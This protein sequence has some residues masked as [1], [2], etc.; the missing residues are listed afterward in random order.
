M[1]E[2]KKIRNICSG[3]FACYNICPVNAISMPL[4]DEGFFYPIINK[5]KCIKCGLCEQV[6]P[7]LNKIKNTNLKPE[8]VFAAKTKDI[9]TQISSSSGG[10]FS[11]LTKPF[12]KEKG[13]I[14]GVTY[15]KNRVKHICIKS[16]KQLERIKGSKYLQSNVN[17][18][19]KKIKNGLDK[20]K[21]ILFCGTPCQVAGLKRYLKLNKCNL[22]NLFLIDLVCHGVPSYKVFDDYLREN[23]LERDVKK[24]NFRDKLISWSNFNVSYYFEDNKKYTKSHR[25][26]IFYRGY[27]KNYYLRKSCYNCQFAK[28]PRQGDITLGDFWGIQKEYYD[29]NGISFVLINNKK[30]ENLFNRISNQIIKNKFNINNAVKG[31]PRII[32]GEYNCLEKRNQFFIEYLNNSFKYVKNKYL[33][34]SLLLLLLIKIKQ[35]KEFILK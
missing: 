24:I 30:G 14:Y 16:E 31:N 9:S 3:C 1:I 32:Q 13:E 26:D 18:S 23:F 34:I 29:K 33:K 12:F 27:L 22:K 4:N 10:I 7:V 35:V 8:F 6:C 2:N 28:I 19:F 5:N 15:E 25:E 21:R 20:R 11:E 17:L